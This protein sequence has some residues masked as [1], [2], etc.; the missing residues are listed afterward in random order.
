YSDLKN[1][2]NLEDPYSIN[3]FAVFKHIRQKTKYEFPATFGPKSLQLMSHWLKMRKE[4]AALAVSA[5]EQ[6][7]GAEV[8]K[9][10]HQDIISKVSNKL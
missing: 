3:H 8:D 2:L 6:I 10:K 7:L 9:N 5:A 1:F 4:V